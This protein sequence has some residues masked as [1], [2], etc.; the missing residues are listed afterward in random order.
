MKRRDFLKVLASL[1]A[2]SLAKPGH[3]LANAYTSLSEARRVPSAP[4]IDG[5]LRVGIVSLGSVSR[6]MLSAHLPHLSYLSRSVSIDSEAG[7]HGLFDRHIVICDGIHP[8][9]S[10]DEAIRLGVKA[11]PLIE[12]AVAGL[13]VLFI[14]AGM[15]GIIGSGIAPI[16]ARIAKEQNVSV[17]LG[18]HYLPF[19]FEGDKQHLNASTGIKALNRHADVVFPISHQMLGERFTPVERERVTLAQYMDLTDTY[20]ERIYSSIT[21]ACLGDGLV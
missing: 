2:V 6:K 20:V 19:G 15:G 10:L 16:V 9:K 3:A 17:V 7:G 14:V 11:G 18:I 21:S 4:I 1:V 12:E 13:D 5:S 8:P